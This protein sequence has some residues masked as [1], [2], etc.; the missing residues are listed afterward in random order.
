[1]DLESTIQI[2]RWTL[3]PLVGIFFI[4]TGISNFIFAYKYKEPENDFE[5]Y[6]PIKKITGGFGYYLGEIQRI[7]VK[8]KK[9]Y[10]DMGITAIVLGLIF[11]AMITFFP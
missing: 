4:A 3:G 7:K 6:Q 2:I 5:E 11:G 1:M 10:I 8:R 9:D